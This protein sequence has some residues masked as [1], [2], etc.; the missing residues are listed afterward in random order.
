MLGRFCVSPDL[1][2]VHDLYKAMKCPV[3]AI[4][5]ASKTSPGHQPQAWVLRLVAHQNTTFPH[6]YKDREQALKK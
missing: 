2:P 5:G 1:E 6:P 3:L 4:Y